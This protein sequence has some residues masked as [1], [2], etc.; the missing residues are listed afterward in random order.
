MFNL[1]GDVLAYIGDLGP[2]F[3]GVRRSI[4]RDGLFVFTT[5]R[6]DC[7]GYKLAPTGRYG[8]ADSHVRDVA[9]AGKFEIVAH[10][11][12]TIRVEAG[13]PVTGSIFVL[14]PR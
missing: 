14:K 1:A 13:V 4:S 3:E 10:G 12:R 11:T 9:T 8:H 2:L 7:G 6:A 5:E